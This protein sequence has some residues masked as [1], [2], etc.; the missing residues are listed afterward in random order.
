MD[1]LGPAGKTLF[2]LCEDPAFIDP[3][4][5]NAFYDSVLDLLTQ[6][7]IT[8]EHRGLLPF[9]VWQIFDAMAGFAREDS[10]AC[11]QSFFRL[12]TPSGVCSRTGGVSVPA[13][14]DS[15]LGLIGGFESLP[16][17]FYLSAF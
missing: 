10:S 15:A 9:R 7:Q 1:Q 2:D 13:V 6:K 11:H 17:R 4:K 8:Q 12:G 3:D 16:H 5:W 14:V